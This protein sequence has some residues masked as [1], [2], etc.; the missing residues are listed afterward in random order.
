MNQVQGLE[1]SS[2]SLSA[3]LASTSILGYVPGLW[4]YSHLNNTSLSNHVQYKVQFSSFSP[5]L[6][7]TW[8]IKIYFTLT[9]A[10]MVFSEIDNHLTV[11]VVSKDGFISHQALGYT[12]FYISYH[13]FSLLGRLITGLFSRLRFQSCFSSTVLS[14]Y[15]WVLKPI[16]SEFSVLH[17]PSFHCPRTS[18]LFKSSYWVHYYL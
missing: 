14:S 12:Q 10:E 13:C 3:P 4:N 7:L 5:N 11:L 17:F 2:E 9:T 6:L 18:P 15:S 8:P 16:I 1:K